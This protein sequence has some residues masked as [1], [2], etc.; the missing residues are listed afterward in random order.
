M[1]PSRSA[2]SS[3]PYKSPDFHG[4]LGKKFTPTI[5]SGP[6]QKKTPH[7]YFWKICGELGVISPRKNTVQKFKG[8]PFQEFFTGSRLEIEFQWFDTQKLIKKTLSNLTQMCGSHL[9]INQTMAVCIWIGCQG[10]HD[11]WNYI[12]SISISIKI[13]FISGT[14]V[15]LESTKTAKTEFILFFLVCFHVFFSGTWDLLRSGYVTGRHQRTE[16]PL[17][18][19]VRTTKGQ[20]T[21]KTH[22]RPSKKHRTFVFLNTRPFVELIPRLTHHTTKTHQYM[23]IRYF[24]SRSFAVAPP[25]ARRWKFARRS[26]VVFKNLVPRWLDGQLVDVATI[27]DENLETLMEAK[28]QR[29]EATKN[30]Q[31]F[32]MCRSFCSNTGSSP[33]CLAVQWCIITPQKKV[34]IPGKMVFLLMFLKLRWNTLEINRQLYTGDEIQTTLFGCYTWCE[35]LVQDVTGE[36]SGILY[37]VGP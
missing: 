22:P 29:N 3:Y 19:F 24:L 7:L 37:K 33:C 13:C 35:K 20:P 6:S 34:E 5:G 21:K 23:W 4:S 18:T 30:P 36:I 25:Y 15:H 28:L 27:G 16:A 9:W 26:F 10:W 31:L 32:E 8:W 12:P 14:V 11:S 17:Y 2:P 1:I